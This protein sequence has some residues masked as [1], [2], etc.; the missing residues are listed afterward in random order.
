[1][2]I[3]STGVYLR[4]APWLWGF[5]SLFAVA[6]PAQSGGAA[7]F[8]Q[9]TRIKLPID[10]GRRAEIRGQMHP[11]LMQSID[12][13]EAPADLRA[14]R[15]V[16]LL[17]ASPA[18]DAALRQFLQNVQTPG[19]PEFHR[20]LTP[21][22]FGQRF[23]V[24]PQDIQVVQGWLKAK[25]FHIDEVPAGGRAIVFSGS[26]GGLNAAFGARIRRF[27]WRGESHIANSTNPTV[28]QALSEVIAGFASLHDFRHRPQIAGARVLPQ[29]TAGS[30][31][32]LVPGD[33]ATIYDLVTPYAQ[34]TT[35]FGRSIVVIGRSNVQSVDLSDF[36]SNFG[37]SAVLPTIVFANSANQAPMLVSG[38]ELES[39]LDL[40]WA[41]AVAPSATIEFVT[42]ASTGLTD[43]V[44]LAAQW[45]VTHNLADII[46]VSYAGCESAADVSGGT[47]F[48]NQIWQ[49]A[50]AQG[51]SVFVASGDAGAAGCDAPTESTATGGLAVNAV[52]SSPYST[53]VGGTQFSADVANPA[54]YW[55]ATNAGSTLASA[56][57]YIGEAVWNQSGTTLYSSGGG[58]SRY[59]AKPAWQLSVG[60]PSDGVRDVP[61]VALNASS[62]HDAYLIVSSDGH[63]NGTI[64]IVGGTS[65]SAPSMAG[66][67]ALVVQK[68]NGRVGNFSPVLY[69]LSANQS[70]GGAAIFHRVTAGNNSV[71]GQDGYSA[72][73][74][75]PEYSQAAGLGSV[76]GAQLI[77]HWQD[78]IGTNTG[79]APASVVVPPGVVV[80][81][82]TFTAAPATNWTAKV[83][84]GAASWLSVSPASG[85]GSAPL[86]FATTANSSS[87]PRTGT[88]TLDGQ[89]LTVTQ[90]AGSGT[91]GTALLNVSSVTFKT[92]PVGNAAATQRVLVSDS[93]DASLTLGSIG[94]AGTA[95]GDF[96][97]GGSCISGLVLGP[98][99]SC[100]LDVGFDPS[101]VG[102]RTATLQIGIAGGAA[103]LV[104]LSGTGAPPEG[105]S[106]DGPL[107]LWSYAMCAVLLLLIGARQRGILG[108][109]AR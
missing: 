69:G 74:S 35:G 29:Y 30:S 33:F 9:P 103:L 99:A 97:S 39:D 77:A 91:Q 70:R 37:L 8:S 78:F 71:P 76:D 65:A 17:R 63:P 85:T 95:A 23:G 15:V 6:M 40:E 104:S 51:M 3:N 1:M 24:A 62:A 108:S 54:T 109:T 52:C 42:T 83:D 20:W 45:A 86:A 60:V 89:V 59:F 75:D 2:M 96:S 82:A 55:S 67:A 93:G 16:M 56:L 100:Y 25:G 48:F 72:S 22:S 13:G 38:D 34:G 92:D 11:A 61:D 50:A 98:G 66:I 90:A 10:E 81:S 32:Y 27:Q 107:P 94:F 84:T 58:A 46:S 105:A 36:R 12:R 53:C 49:Q 41:A 7:A 4:L 19:R 88:I 57:G 21:E 43:G 87:S 18:Q 73:T 101:A 68:Q 28:P 14:D 47:T 79:L 26:V 31:H 106:S 80:G 102:A 5:A 64:V 44:D